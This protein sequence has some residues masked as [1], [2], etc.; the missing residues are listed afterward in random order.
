MA[1]EKKI[2]SLDP[3]GLVENAFLLGVGVLEMTKEKTQGFANEL[4]ERGKMSQSEAKKVADQLGTIAE[5]QRANLRKTV[6][7]ETEK[8]MANG[9]VATK[10]E[11]AGLRDEIA[12]LKAMIASLK[13]ESQDPS[14]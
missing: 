9:G 13:P 12:E 14:A 2:E 4:I 5:E 11:V 1:D 3:A 10:T 6:A 8:V 7:T